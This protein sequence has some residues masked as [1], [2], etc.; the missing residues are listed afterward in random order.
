MPTIDFPGPPTAN[1]FSHAAV[2]APGSRLVHTSGQVAID[3]DG[4]IPEGWEAQTRLVFHNLGE[5]LAS[6]GATWADVVKL[7]WFVTDT[8]DLATIRRVRD[9]FVDV[10]RPPASSLIRVAG[11][12]RP[13]LLVEVE[14]V[15]AVPA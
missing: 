6:A 2:V 14:A 11:L 15:A 3:A 12:F 8:S 10:T 13:G 9:E 4:T 7:T 1:G 5:V